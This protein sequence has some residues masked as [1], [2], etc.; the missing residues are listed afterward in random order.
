[1][2]DKEC[3]SKSTQVKS[4]KLNKSSRDMCFVFI[5]NVI[6]NHHFI[7]H[8]SPIMISWPDLIISIVLATVVFVDGAILNT[9]TYDKCHY[10]SDMSHWKDVS[11]GVGIT[12]LLI[13]IGLG[14][15]AAF[16]EFTEWVPGFVYHILRVVLLCTVFGIAVLGIVL[17]GTCD[18]A[19]QSSVSGYFIYNI[20]TAV[21]G[22]GYLSFLIYRLYKA[23]H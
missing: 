1:M 12:A 13:G 8:C 20:T 19:E 17:Y 5:V 10:A 11:L 21:V 15:N 6:T 2:T 3:M 22:V 14:V 9:I 23:H 16:P 4:S 18:S 7:F